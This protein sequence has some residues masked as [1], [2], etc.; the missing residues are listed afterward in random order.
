MP[1]CDGLAED[2]LNELDSK[3]SEEELDK[4][5]PWRKH[6]FKPIRIFDKDGNEIDKEELLKKFKEKFYGERP[7]AVL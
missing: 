6:S 4:K 3:L 7:D 2:F 5:Y 1:D